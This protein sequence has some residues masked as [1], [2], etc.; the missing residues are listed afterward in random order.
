MFRILLA[1]VVAAV[2][3][4][5][6]SAPEYR[7]E[8][9]EADSIA[10]VDPMRAMAMLDSMRPAMADAPEHEQMYYRLICIKAD[11]KA[12]IEHESDTSILPVVEYYETKGDK[13]LLSEAYYYAGNTY[14]DMNDAPRA[15]EYYQK[16]E[17]T[18][19]D[20]ATLRER[21]RLQNQQAH[22]F[23]SQGIHD[24]AIIRFRKAYDYEAQKEDTA[25]MAYC[26]NNIAY[27]FSEKKEMDSS[28]YYYNKAYALAK[29][30]KN[31]KVS[32]NILGQIASLY[33][34]KMIM[35]L[36]INI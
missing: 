34:R 11:D 29:L 21:S 4:A 31:K 27:T 33:T 5:S 2:C 36:H 6:C 17:R 18:L 10:S 9:K 25:M 14:R 20:D 23:L 24:E 26:M 28:L 16:A 8:L 22:L 12:Y 35:K 15:L 13:H 30:H 19:P 1:A 7:R 32:L 3:F